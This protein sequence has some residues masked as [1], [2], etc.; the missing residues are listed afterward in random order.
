MEEFVLSAEVR[1]QRGTRAARRLREDGRLPGNLYGH[2][3]PN[4][5]VTLDRKE[6]TTFL[7]EGHRVLALQIGSEREHSVVKEVQYDPM[8]SE[9]VHVDF[10]RIS[11]DE[12]I[13][14]EVPIELVG[15]PK[16]V[17]SGGILDF[18]HKEVLVSGF[19]RHIPELIS[20]RVEDLEI[21]GAVRIHDLPV[22]EQ[23][24]FVENGEMIVATVSAPRVEAEPESGA[25]ETEGSEPEV[26]QQ[27]K[28]EEGGE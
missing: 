15:V 16:G 25:E 9:I 4:V 3:E 22:P 10:T 27:R 23:C 18:P 11:A 14:V 7:M 24:E 5:H 28:E 26:I 12:S 6:F 13:Q 20:V 2:K 1:E 8:G 19:P 21:G 17:S